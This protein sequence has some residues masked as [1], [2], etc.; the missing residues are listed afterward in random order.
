MKKKEVL[1]STNYVLSFHTTRIAYG[2]KSYG[3]RTDSP[4]PGSVGGGGGRRRQM[5]VTHPFVSYGKIGVG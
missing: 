3:A 1:G 5:A 4:S 2:R